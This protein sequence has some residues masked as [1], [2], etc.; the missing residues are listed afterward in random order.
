MLIVLDSNVFTR[1]LRLDSVE[2]ELLAAFITA[3]E[4]ARLAAPR[5]SIEEAARR[6]CLEITK[7][8]YFSRHS[9]AMLEKLLGAPA[10]PARDFDPE[11]FCA[12]YAAKIQRRLKRLGAEILE[13]ERFSAQT[14]LDRPWGRGRP[15]QSTKDGCEDIL[16]WEMLKTDCLPGGED[17][18]LISNRTPFFCQNRSRRLRSHLADELRREGLP[19][20]NLHV[21]K[22][23]D[24]FLDTHARPALPVAQNALSL[25]ENDGSLQK[26]GFDLDAWFTANKFELEFELKD[27]CEDIFRHVNLDLVGASLFVHDENIHARSLS[28]QGVYKLKGRDVV[29]HTA[30]EFSFIF[31]VFIMCG[32]G[33]QIYEV[34][35]RTPLDVHV[36]A[37]K[38][39][40]SWG[41]FK[42]SIPGVLLITFNTGSKKVKNHQFRL[43]EFFGFC[44]HCGECVTSD[45][46]VSCA[47][48][49]KSL[50]W[51]LNPSQ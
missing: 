42:V 17:V 7:H 2:L 25:F 13:Y 10:P 37:I 4:D 38:Q 50:A 3:H 19:L 15:D 24:E 9:A 39:H 18:V 27:R 48:C 23:L 36:D 29:F 43:R 6:A 33:S 8:R 14:I 51:S 1:D 20:E 40:G 21:V 31:D 47:R 11:S 44:P 34:L 22:N 49:E 32:H 16:L 5:F 35:E 12:G 46:A 45:V 26:Y 30:A 41:H 28:I